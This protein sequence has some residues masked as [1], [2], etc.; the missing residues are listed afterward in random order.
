MLKS[1]DSGKEHK[2]TNIGFIELV[3]IL[4][5]AIMVLR[6]SDIPKVARNIGKLW[7]SLNRYRR[8]L[9]SEFQKLSKLDIETNEEQDDSKIDDSASAGIE[10]KELLEA[11][12]IPEFRDEESS[13]SCKEDAKEKNRRTQV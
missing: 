11:A 8:L 7:G 1:P 2:T 5:V 13:D 9:D 3:V 12:P 4:I 10:D 6:P